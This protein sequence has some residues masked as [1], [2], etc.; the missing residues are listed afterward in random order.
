MPRAEN[1]DSSAVLN[2]EGPNPGGSEGSN[3]DLDAGSPVYDGLSDPDNS[4]N[5][6]K[7]VDTSDLQR[8]TSVL[9]EVQCSAIQAECEIAKGKQKM[10]KTYLG[11]SKK[12]QSCHKQSHLL[13]ASCGF[14]DI[15]SFMAMKEKEK[16]RV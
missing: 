8:F 15:F 4:P 13:L 10:P 2:L 16:A 7:I 1:E 11:N 6:A 5:D 3:A 9:K 14:H 12:T